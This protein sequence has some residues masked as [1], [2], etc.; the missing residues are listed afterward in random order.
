VHDVPYTVVIPTKDRHEILPVTIGHLLAQT[1]PPRRVVVVDASDEPMRLDVEAGD[2]E[3]VL[4]QHAPSTSAQRNFGLAHV[5]TPLV[6]FH[7]DDVELPPNYVE[8]LKRRWAQRGGLEAL[9]AATGTATR[10]APAGQKLKQ[11]YRRVFQLHID[12]PR[13]THSTFRLSQ[14]IRFR[15]DPAEPVLIPA[16]ST[17][18]VLYRTDLA[19][20]HPFDEHFPGYALGEDLDMSVRVAQEAPILHVPDVAYVHPWAEG[21]RGSARR[22]YYRGRCDTYFRLKRLDPGPVPAAAFALSLIG[23]LIGAAA[24]SAKE[25][26]PSHLGLFVKGLAETLRERPS[27]LS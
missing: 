9:G 25:R 19:R 14:K 20:K 21:N 4:L 11:F 12:D 10:P 13:V 15:L 17:G 26:D 23:E 3:L 16:V 22:W 8:T 18:A 1:D 7:D 6:M 24:D 27:G 5:E 2:V